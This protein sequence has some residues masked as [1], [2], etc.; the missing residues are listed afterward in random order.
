VRLH[1]DARL[2]LS[3]D[4]IRALDCSKRGC[5]EKAVMVVNGKVYCIDHARK[6]EGAMSD[7]SGVWLD[8]ALAKELYW[9]LDG[10]ADEKYDVPALS[11][12]L[13]DA[14]EKTE[15]ALA[16]VASVR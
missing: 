15:T 5:G 2:D 4:E 11:S 3:D 13:G 8:L 7:S 16:E 12:A 6:A 14:I 10:L 9:A 1:D